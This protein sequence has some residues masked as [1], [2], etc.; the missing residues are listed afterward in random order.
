MTSVVI[1]SAQEK[2]SSRPISLMYSWPNFKTGFYQDN[3]VTAPTLIIHSEAKYSRYRNSQLLLGSNFPQ[4]AVWT[5]RLKV[6]QN[7]VLY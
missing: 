5:D 4:D 7:Y 1:K 3:H 2:G 6:T